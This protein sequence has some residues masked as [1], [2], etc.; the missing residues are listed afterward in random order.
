LVIQAI[1]FI[2]QFKSDKGDNGGEIE[3][4]GSRVT[5]VPTVLL[6]KGEELLK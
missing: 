1:D 5:R 3:G 6:R 4:K 2:E